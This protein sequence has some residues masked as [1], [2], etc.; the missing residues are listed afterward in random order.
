MKKQIFLLIALS[1]IFLGNAQRPGLPRLYVTDFGAIGDGSTLNTAFIQKAIDAAHAKKGAYVIFPKGRFLTGSLIL[2]SNVHLQLKKEAVLLGST[3]PK[4]Y[5]RMEIENP[6]ISPKTD[7]NS[8]LALLLA[9][10]SKNISISG[11]GSIDGQGRELAL[12][13]DSLHHIGEMVDPTYVTRVNETMRPKI[14]NFGECENISV[15]DITIKNAANWVQT[16]ELSENVFIN[17]VTVDSRAYWNNDG[18]NITDC[19]HVRIKNCTINSADDGLTLKSYYPGRFNEDVRITN[20]SIR[21][22][23]SAIKF[24]TASIGGFKNIFIDSIEVRDTFRSAI[25]LEAVDGGFI[26]NVT[27]SNINAHNTGNA[28]F[29][30]LGN[31]SGDGNGY[32][33][34]V[35]F[36]NIKAQIPFGRPDIDYDLRGPSVGFFH[37]PIPASITGFPD[38]HITDVVLENIEIIYPGRASKGMAYVPLWRLDAVPE[39]IKD[40]PEFSMF[41]ELPSWGFYIRHINGISFKNVILKLEDS[42]FRPA[43]VFDD[44]QNISLENFQL[45]DTTPEQ[46][47]L[48]AS[49]LEKISPEDSKFVK[50]LD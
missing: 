21:S 15:S 5:T 38:N 41:G 30:R 27:V 46:I 31:R 17:N 36:K 23:A 2:K 1:L 12:K 7:D 19:S 48:K 33:K 32:V 47:I 11:Q 44:V 34:N 6:P 3:N 10:R 16:Y 24:G 14:I 45:P 43:M 20:C 50:Y 9:S 28:L 22:S 25:A 13:I 37:N 35:I 26:E 39:K 49:R 42:D 29:V 18:L 8:K 4:H 40:Y